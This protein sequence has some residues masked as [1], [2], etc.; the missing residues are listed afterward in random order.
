M[1]LHR[2]LRCRPLSAAME[3]GSRVL[4]LNRAFGSPVIAKMVRT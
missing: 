2:V 3:A 1:V 4:G